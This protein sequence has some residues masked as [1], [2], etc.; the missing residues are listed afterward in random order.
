LPSRRHRFTGHTW[1]ILAVLWVARLTA[2]ALDPAATLF[3]LAAFGLLV[4]PT[5]QRERLNNNALD[6]AGTILRRV[7]FAYA[8]ASAVSLLVGVGESRL[9]L[10]VAGVSAPEPH[11]RAW[12]AVQAR[13]SLR[14]QET[15][16][17]TLI[18]G[19]GEIAR[20][21]IS[22]LEEHHEYG[23]NVIGVADDDPKFDGGELGARLVGGLRDLPDLVRSYDIDVVIVAFSNGSQASQ[24]EVIRAAM[25][26]GATVW[27]VPRFFELGASGHTKDHL[28]GIPVVRLN[29]P[30]RSRPEWIIKRAID[31]ALAAVGCIVLAPVL[32]VITLA[33]LL[34][35]GRPDPSE[36][37][38]RWH[39]R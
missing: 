8:I 39:R 25:A 28:W 11:A 1:I 23:L 38:T 31:F 16:S 18:V 15:A 26:G 36:A 9:L 13:R 37:T 2:G 17:R 3:G 33:V 10:G 35:S 7:A 20:K 30:A 32:G 19:G 12:A 6:D 24:V 5:V 4:S 22:T 29:L 21:V 34:E 14:R 27:V